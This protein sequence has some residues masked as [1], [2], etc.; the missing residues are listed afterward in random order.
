MRERDDYVNETK[1]CRAGVSVWLIVK[2]GRGYGRI[3]V[4][5]ARSGNASFITLNMCDYDSPGLTE[6]TGYERVPSVKRDWVNSGIARLLLRHKEKLITYCKFRLPDS[7]ETLSKSW[8]D[9]I[10]FSGYK[11]IQAL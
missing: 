4:R 5:N 2:D 8:E 11:A 7:V 1:K 10:E 6:I 9:F 3:T